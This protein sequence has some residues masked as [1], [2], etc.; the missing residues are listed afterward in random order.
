M[1]PTNGSSDKTRPE[2]RERHRP[3]IRW[4]DAVIAALIAA[5]VPIV[6][7]IGA[8][9]YS[10]IRKCNQDASDMETQLTSILL[11]IS[12][13]EERM[14]AMLDALEDKDQPVSRE[15]VYSELPL[16]E[17]G[18]DGRSG[19]PEFKDRS[20]LNLLNQYNRLLRRV[21][22]P[23]G[24]CSAP[25]GSPPTGSLKC[26]NSGFQ[27]KPNGLAANGHAVIATLQF[28]KAEPNTFVR[29]ITD[30]LQE[31]TLQQDWHEHYGPMHLCEFWTLI[32][33]NEPWKL[34]G[35][36]ERV[37]NSKKGQ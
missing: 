32:S 9:Y 4:S 11:E 30:D 3:M 33:T 25:T 20:L 8:G 10:A 18:T 6:A 24:F 31:I 1:S 37:A 27:T 26:A 22:F 23:D 12:G 35:L 17:S 16:I 15:G 28:T 2:G 13:R 19:N 5:L 34:I 29:N 7:S 21:Q 14:K 36:K